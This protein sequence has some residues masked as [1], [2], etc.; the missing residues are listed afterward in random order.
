MAGVDVV[1]VGA[2]PAGCA[3]GITAARAGAR[4]LVLDRAR[5]PRPKTC[6]DAI[7][8]RAAEL[9]A[10][11]CGV[12]TIDDALAHVPSARVDRGVAILPDAGAIER[13]FGARPGYIVPRLGLDDRLRH[14][15]EHAGASLRQGTKVTGLVRERERVVGV[16]I[17]GGEVVRGDVVIAADGP[18]SI[19][20]F[21]LGEPY[22]RGRHLAVALTAYVE[23]LRPGPW[24]AAAEH[25]FEPGLRAG[26][27]WIF[28][29][30]EGLA[31]VGV[32]QRADRFH[33]HGRSLKLLFD[34]FR[35]AHRDRF[36]D[37]R[38][39]GRT[40]TW[41][42][43]LAVPP[44]PRTAPG[45]LVAGD[46]GSCVDPL[47]GEGIWQAL[48]TGMLA[49]GVAGRGQAHD[50]AAVA[51]LAR[52]RLRDIGVP[53]LLRLGIQDAMDGLIATGLH[54]RALVRALLRRGYASESLEASKRLR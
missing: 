20:Q 25:Y 31:N 47:A 37:A 9:V 40:R 4:V 15:L 43:P 50:R 6:G 12:D 23:G 22:R 33:A 13:S 18:G 39:C 45:L 1:V 29:P 27:G 32:Y 42:L 16:T 10:A 52:R 41:A 36:A 34:E 5:F 54:R 14:A 35:A 17:E 8:N 44:A 53:S 7:S 24:P 2:G 21:G 30:V 26:Y 38:L 49:G 19:A 51:A 11:L 28:P 46:A 3:A 48:H